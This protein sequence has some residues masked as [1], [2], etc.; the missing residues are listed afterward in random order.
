VS[1]EESPLYLFTWQQAGVMTENEENGCVYVYDIK[2]TSSFD[3]QK[4]MIKCHGGQEI[5][6]KISRTGHAILIWSN[7]LTD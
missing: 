4:F 5:K 2:A 7:N 1:L 6:V 3:K